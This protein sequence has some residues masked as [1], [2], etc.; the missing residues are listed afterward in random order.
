MQS[1]MRAGLLLFIPLVALSWFIVTAILGALGVPVAWLFGIVLGGGLSVALYVARSRKME[2][3]V[4]A[5]TL[6]LDARGITQVNPVATRFVSWDGL[7]GGRMVKP[8]IGMST[9]KMGRTGMPSRTPGVD[10]LASAAAT[11]ELGLVGIGTI[12]LASSAGRMNRET[13]RQNEARNGVDPTTGQPLVALYPQQF[14]AAWP[15]ERIGDW[16]QHYRPDV[17]AEAKAIWEQQP[18]SKANRG[19]AHG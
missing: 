10:A 17:F 7:R 2:A 12:T 11:G 14:D 4:G 5:M 9:G 6:T 1:S 13:Y 19:A 3:E 15:D 18:R 8:V 16:V